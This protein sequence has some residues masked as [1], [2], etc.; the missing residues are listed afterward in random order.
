MAE[1]DRRAPAAVVFDALG[2]AYER[3][4]AGSAP[5]RASLGRLV[6]LLAPGS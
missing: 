1:E 5:H 6:E 4:F 3:A 2:P